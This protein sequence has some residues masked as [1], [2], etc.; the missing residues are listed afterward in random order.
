MS[1]S[2][3]RRDTTGGCG[4]GTISP[5]TQPRSIDQRDDAHL[6]YEPRRRRP[7]SGE[8]PDAFAGRGYHLAPFFPPFSQSKVT[9]RVRVSFTPACLVLPLQGPTPPRTSQAAPRDIYPPFIKT[10]LF[11][12]MSDARENPP[13]MPTGTD[14]KKTFNRA[15]ARTPV[16]S[17]MGFDDPRLFE[18][19]VP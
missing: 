19:K 16:S 18:K 4:W 3:A 7:G 1:P 9:E 14:A 10:R 8:R 5:T 17:M 13:P 11:S 15:R 12:F 2:C 6:R